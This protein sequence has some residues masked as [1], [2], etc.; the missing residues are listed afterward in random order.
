MSNRLIL[1]TNT[2]PYGKGETFL[3]TEIDFLSK[4][5]QQVIICPRYQPDKIRTVPDNVRVVDI[6]RHNSEYGKMKLYLTGILYF[7]FNY[8]QLKNIKIKCHCNKLGVLKSLKYIGLII[9]LKTNVQKFLKGI[10][11]IQNTIFYTYWLEHVTVALGLIKKKSDHFKLISRAHRYD[12]Y[13][14]YGDKS[15]SFFKEANMHLLDRL[16]LI[17]QHGIHYMKQKYPEYS[18]KYALS[19]LGTNKPEQGVELTVQQPYRIVSCSNI[20]PVKRIDKII[21]ALK[22]FH[23]TYN[24][25]HI[26]WH[27]LGDGTERQAL[28]TMSGKELKKDVPFFFH[29]FIDNKEIFEFYRMLKP[30]MLI[31]VSE[32]EG[33]PVS[34]MEAQSLGMPIVA[35]DVGGVSEIVD[36]KNGYLLSS[37]PS[38]KEI[39]DALY[40]LLT[41]TDLEELGKE[42]ERNWTT[43]FNAQINYQKFT[44]Q[45]LEL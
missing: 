30:T 25:I 37:N 7:I 43:N 4:A 21:Q 28:E 22:L 41:K 36:K 19:Y 34:M 38:S 31:N 40:Y 15:F 10:S 11:N 27:H 44:N 29:G 33:L 18:F 17:S 13:E 1:F 12:L 23:E 3:E 32:S 35:A 5:F 26:E 20:A 42:A 45:I 8:Q 16:F 6:Y 14:E 9:L 2:Y 24:D 39:V